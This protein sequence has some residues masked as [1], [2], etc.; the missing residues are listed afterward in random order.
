MM[1][2]YNTKAHSI[3]EKLMQILKEEDQ[4]EVIA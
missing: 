1:N 2:S 4:E 3:R